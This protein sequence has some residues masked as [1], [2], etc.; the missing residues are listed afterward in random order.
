M[1]TVNVEQLLDE[2]AHSRTD[3]EG[4]A[5]T[6]LN[7]VAF[8]E[9][10]HDLLTRLLDRVD[11]IS[12]RYAS[13]S[14]ILVSELTAAEHT[15]RKEQIQLGV[16]GMP[17]AEMRSIVHSLLVP[18]VRSV[19]I[20][21]GE[22]LDDERFAALAD[23]VNVVV[24]FSSVKDAGV[25]P[26]RELLQLQRM[27]AAAKIR[28]L[29]YL[30][31][32]AWQDLVAQFFDDPEVAAELQSISRVEVECGSQPEAYYLAGW[33]A[34][35]LAWEPCAPGEFCNAQGAKISVELRK[36]GAPRR[37]STIRL[38]SANYVFGAEIEESADDLVCLTV[39]GKKPRDQ[40]CLPLHD[41]DMVSLI[42]RAI[43]E[44]GGTEV[45]IQSLSMVG[46]LLE[47]TP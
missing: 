2:L 24:L 12:A 38:Q 32:F 8:V 37:I 35:R 30:R 42:E 15:V 23:L 22:H 36:K 20:W 31:L 47:Y 19:L 4:V 25:E 46:K 17:A 43:F 6:S 10:D 18:D 39:K 5:T 14:I 11:A 40:R 3:S 28:D 34:S 29:S 27:N 45:F 41:V 26:L 21:A 9:R 13:R 33:L 16:G 7:V 1:Q 44:S